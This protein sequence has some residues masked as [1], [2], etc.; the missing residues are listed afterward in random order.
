[1]NDCVLI[2]LRRVSNGFTI[3]LVPEHEPRNVKRYVASFPRH[4]YSTEISVADIIGDIAADL[5]VESVEA[6]TD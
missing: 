5:E 4:S 1:M 2:Y 6:E 3:T